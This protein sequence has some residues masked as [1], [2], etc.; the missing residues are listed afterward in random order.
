MEDNSKLK[1]ERDGNLVVFFAS[2]YIFLMLYWAF[3]D[4][5][6]GNFAELV[7]WYTLA[8]V[9][10]R[11]LTFCFNSFLAKIIKRRW[12]INRLKGRVSPIYR[13]KESHSQYKVVKYSVEYTKLCLDWV[14]P[15]STL[16]LEQE[17]VKQGEYKTNSLRDVVDLE[18]FFEDADKRHKLNLEAQNAAKK[19]KKQTIEIL[20]RTFNDNYK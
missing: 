5:D 2:G 8:V 11:I 16:F 3:S 20:N 19:N 13:I 17:Y 12:K 9:V 14:I 10:Y 15:F 7:L 6:L 1:E 4:R 18:K